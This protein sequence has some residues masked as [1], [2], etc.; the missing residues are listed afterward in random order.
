MCSENFTITI[1]HWVIGL[2][3]VAINIPEREKLFGFKNFDD[4]EFI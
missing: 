4:H 2:L 1:L 3:T